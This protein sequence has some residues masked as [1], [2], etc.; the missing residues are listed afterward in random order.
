MNR[1]YWMLGFVLL[2]ACKGTS[3]SSPIAAD[4]AALAAD[5]AEATQAGDSATSIV[6]IPLLPLT[7]G[8]KVTS[9]D[10]AATAAAAAASFFIP[11]GCVTTV[12]ALNVLTYT[13]NDCTGPFGLVHVS[14][15]LVATFTPSTSADSV[16]V[17]V[18]SEG[19]TLNQLPV[20]QQATA[21]IGYVGLY[22]NL[23]WK[24]SF[25]GRNAKGLDIVHTADYVVA[26]DTVSGCVEVKGAASTDIGA[27]GVETFTTDYRRCGNSGV[28]PE[29]GTITATGRVSGLT[30]S[31]T[32]LGAGQAELTGPGGKTYEYTLAWCKPQ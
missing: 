6:S 30:I 11:A 22:R 16:V 28:C 19:L 23:T 1:A 31:V 20:S 26:A 15:K 8:A 32:Y 25:A 7:D 5:T 17:A 2:A 4:Q 9:P 24:G 21:V 18:A 27:R 13:F 10:T 14:G 29:A 3:T 12:K